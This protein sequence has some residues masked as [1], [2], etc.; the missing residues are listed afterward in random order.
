MLLCAL[1][2]AEWIAELAGRTIESV[3]DRTRIKDRLAR[4][5][6]ALEADSACCTGGE[7]AN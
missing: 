3:H 7:E 1:E 5:R 6:E 2:Q 4:V